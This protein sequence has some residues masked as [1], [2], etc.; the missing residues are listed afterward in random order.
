MFKNGIPFV[1]LDS[2]GNFDLDLSKVFSLKNEIKDAINESIRAAEDIQSESLKSFL[3]LLLR[4]NVRNLGNE[5]LIQNNPGEDKQNLT[6]ATPSGANTPEQMAAAVHNPSTI[7]SSCD[8]GI[9]EKSGTAEHKPSSSELTHYIRESE[10]PDGFK[11]QNM[12]EQ[13]KLDQLNQNASFL[14]DFVLKNSSSELQSSSTE[15]EISLETMVISSTS[16]TE[17]NPELDM[18]TLLTTAGSNYKII[19]TNKTSLEMENEIKELAASPGKPEQQAVK[20]HRRP[21]SLDKLEAVKDTSP[22]SIA[23]KTPIV[24][25]GEEKPTTVPDMALPTEIQNYAEVLPP[26]SILILT[27][28]NMDASWM[29]QIVLGLNKLHPEIKLFI[30]RYS[31]H[32]NT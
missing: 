4:E 16:V 12:T 15:S 28:Q 19:P 11:G 7:I 30:T 8:S 26:K 25:E 2:T 18:P 24:I 10:T 6:A 27:S 29:S 20:Q 3:N 21:E 31:I 9:E 22:K 17:S 14:K 23:R 5:Q 32:Q 1:L 13:S